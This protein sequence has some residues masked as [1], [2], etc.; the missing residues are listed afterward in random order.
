MWVLPPE[1]CGKPQITELL[2]NLSLINKQCIL[3]VVLQLIQKTQT[4]YGWV[5]EKTIPRETLP[6]EMEF[7]KPLMVEKHGKIWVSKVQN[8]LVK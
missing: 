2:L 7:T 3:L 1:D 5:P 6:M 4:L 8:T